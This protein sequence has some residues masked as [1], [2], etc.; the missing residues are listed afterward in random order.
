MRQRK[1]IFY[2]AVVVLAFQIILT[3]IEVANSRLLTPNGGWRY[4]SNNGEV[5]VY[6]TYENLRGIR[7]DQN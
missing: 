5:Y 2:V 6:S 3:G 7:W 4:R 1:K